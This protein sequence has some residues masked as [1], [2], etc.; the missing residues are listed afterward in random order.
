MRDFFE[1]FRTLNLHSSADLDA[2]VSQ[3]QAIVSNTSAQQL[4]VDPIERAEVRERMAAVLT[5][6][7]TMTTAA[8]RRRVMRPKRPETTAEPTGQETTPAPEQN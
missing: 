4:R 5:T 8:S 6:L 1:R 7:E 2:L 3:A